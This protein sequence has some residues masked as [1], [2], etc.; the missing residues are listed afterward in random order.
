[1]LT[2]FQKPKLWPIRHKQIIH[3]IPIQLE[4]TAANSE[5]KRSVLVQQEIGKNIIDRQSTDA[6]SAILLFSRKISSYGVGLTAARLTISKA[7][8]YAAF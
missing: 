6:I 3:S 8:G 4:E 2:I 7:R 5:T 1:L